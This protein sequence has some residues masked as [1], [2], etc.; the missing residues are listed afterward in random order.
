MAKINQ[1]SLD[2]G[3]LIGLTTSIPHISNGPEEVVGRR[4]PGA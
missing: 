2:E 3:G 1:Y 4:C